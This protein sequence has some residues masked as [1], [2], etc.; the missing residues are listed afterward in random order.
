MK[1]KI[2]PI[3][4]TLGF[5]LI[6]IC[7]KVAASR[8]DIITLRARQA[9]V[10]AIGLFNSKQS[11]GIRE[12]MEKALLTGMG[13]GPPQSALQ[14]GVGA[15]LWNTCLGP[16]SPSRRDVYTVAESAIQVS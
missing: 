12:K 13:E 4:E 14:I 10:E 2:C 3:D 5:E 16:F 6:D 7:E 15:A 8:K 1:I 11:D 9:A